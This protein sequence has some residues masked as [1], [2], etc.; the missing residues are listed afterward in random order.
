MTGWD[1]L[2]QMFIDNGVPELAEEITRI[3]KENPDSPNTIYEDL[4]KTQV[5]KDRFQGNALLVAQGKKPLSEMEYIQ[6]ETAYSQVLSSFGAGS[7][8]NRANYVKFIGGDIAPTELTDRF[9]LA[10]TRVTKAFD[11]NDES[12]IAELRTMYPGVTNN[13]LATSLLF[14]AE[15]SKYLDTKINRAEIGAAQTDVGIKSALGT[16]L[17]ESKNLTRAQ[18]SSGLSRTGSQLS[19]TNEASRAF[20]ESDTEGIQLELEKENLLGIT[21]QRTKRLASQARGEFGGQSGI[22]T[23]S[24]G[25]KKQV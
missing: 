9:N 4:R 6:N 18:V 7:L 22:S 25:K 15:G 13:E 11:S 17:L 5:Y 3:I 14:G 19:G 10:Y 21:S 8:A 24:L 16:N 2:R 12:L 1:N 20:G 23:G